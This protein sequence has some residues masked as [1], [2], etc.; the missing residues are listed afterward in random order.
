[1]N[2]LAIFKVIPQVCIQF[3]ARSVEKPSVVH[4]WILV[5]SPVEIGHLFL[6]RR[7]HTIHYSISSKVFKPA[8]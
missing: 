8:K 6:L 4:L 2:T 3:G 5:F 1:L 7:G